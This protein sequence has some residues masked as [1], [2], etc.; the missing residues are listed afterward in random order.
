MLIKLLKL[1]RDRIDDHLSDIWAFSLDYGPWI[2]KVTI[3]KE[4]W[5]PGLWAGYEGAKFKI[6]S[7]NM[8]TREIEFEFMCLEE[9][10]SRSK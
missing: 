2:Q 1:I 9:N 7:I 4:D 10:V 3:N 6:K 8:E 5:A